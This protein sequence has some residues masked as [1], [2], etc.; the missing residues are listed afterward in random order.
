[1]PQRVWNFNKFVGTKNSKYDE[2]EKHKDEKYQVKVK[3]KVVPVLQMST[4]P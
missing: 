3:C 2:A 4:M 1:M